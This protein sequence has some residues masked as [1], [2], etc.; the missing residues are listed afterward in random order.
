MPQ[1]RPSESFQS[2]QIT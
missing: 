1:R 2:D